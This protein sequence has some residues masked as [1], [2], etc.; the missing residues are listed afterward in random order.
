[1]TDDENGSPSSSSISSSW[2]LCPCRTKKEVVRGSCARA[3]E[4]KE[5]VR[6]SCARAAEKRK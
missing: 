3:E 2:K 6:G 5:V 1:M 4:K